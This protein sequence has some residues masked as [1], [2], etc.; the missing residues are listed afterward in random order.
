MLDYVPARRGLKLRTRFARRM[1]RRTGEAA[2]SPDEP[3]AVQ[4]KRLD[5]AG[6]LMPAKG[7]DIAAREIA[8]LGALSFTP[9]NARPGR[10]LYFHGG[11]YSRGSARSHKAFVSRLSA[12]TRLEALSVD[13][14]LAPEH[15]CPA[16]VEDAVSAYETLRGETDAR[17]VMAG[18]SA[19]GGLALSACVALRAAG[20]ALPD[21]LVLFSPWTDLT[22]SG[23]SATTR[24]GVDP[25]LKTAYLKAGAALYLG[26]LDAADPVASPLFADLAGL[27][28]TFIQAGEDEVLLDDSVRLHA[29]L[30]AAGVPVQCEIWRG[31]WH[32]FQMFA[33]IAPEAGRA[34]DACAAWVEGVLAALDAA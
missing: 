20:A 26:D 21:A 30:E 5:K 25:M 18:D 24:D 33:P 10:L 15:P 32:D 19:G 22:M 7:V 1:A 34:I 17:I 28:P 23:D 9:P 3:R 16:A 6:D 29:A 13:Y 27:P 31:M 4:R 14:R 11:G 2:L 12:A 8:G